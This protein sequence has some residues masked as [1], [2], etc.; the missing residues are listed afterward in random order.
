MSYWY[1]Q[2]HGWP[3][4]KWKKSD[5]DSIY[6]KF[7]KNA[8]KSI[9]KAHQSGCLGVGDGGVVIGRDCKKAWGFFGAGG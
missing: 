4:T 2:Q 3:H 6:I 8:K 5:N 7:S 1:C 9:Q